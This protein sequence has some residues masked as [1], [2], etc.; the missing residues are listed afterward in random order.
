MSAFKVRYFMR[1]E[2]TREWPLNNPVLPEQLGLAIWDMKDIGDRVLLPAV[3]WEGETKTEWYELVE[4][5]ERLRVLKSHA[6]GKYL[7]AKKE[8]LPEGLTFQD[9]LNP[10][11]RNRSSVVAP[12]P[13]S[14]GPSVPKHVLK[15]VPRAE[16]DPP[17]EEISDSQET[18][19]LG[20]SPK[21]PR[22]K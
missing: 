9:S 8:D 7:H 14:E 18:L 4:S 13:E 11:A 21:R 6:S 15:I 20:Q 22:T 10:F 12:A 5:S 2:V 1:R 3:R 19:V 17:E 16:W